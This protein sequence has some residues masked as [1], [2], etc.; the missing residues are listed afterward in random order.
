MFNCYLSQFNSASESH[1]GFEFFCV[2]VFSWSINLILLDYFPPSI[3]FTSSIIHFSQLLYPSFVVFI[4]RNHQNQNSHNMLYNYN[5]KQNQYS[6]RKRKKKTLIDWIWLSKWFA[7][8][9]RDYVKSN[10]RPPSDLILTNLLVNTKANA[11]Y[12]NILTAHVS[13]KCSLF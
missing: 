13:K 10:I 2:Y 12:S 5:Q 7:F 8:S 9:D 6:F 11:I 3:L 1:G 4:E